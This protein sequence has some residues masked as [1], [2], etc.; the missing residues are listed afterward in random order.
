[1]LTA[2]FC[3][4]TVIA[5]TIDNTDLPFKRTLAHDHGHGLLKASSKEK[6]NLLVMVAVG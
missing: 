3:V 1:M 2:T 4:V 6:V 5:K